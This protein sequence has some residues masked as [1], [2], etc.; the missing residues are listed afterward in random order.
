MK[1]DLA[2]SIV[3]A[4]ICTVV[5]YFVCNIFLPASENV[6]FKVISGDNNYSLTDP[7]P[8]IFNFRALNPTVEVF[9]GDCSEYGDNGECLD[10][11]DS[12]PMDDAGDG[13]AVDGDTINEGE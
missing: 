1:A 3:T 4:V 8:E 12:T 6:S 11:I 7:D 5:G 13:G 9:V 2:T 10:D